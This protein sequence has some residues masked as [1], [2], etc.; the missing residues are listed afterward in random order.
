[1]HFSKENNLPI[2]TPYGS[3]LQYHA[4]CE[5]L[6]EL[7]RRMTNLEWPRAKTEGWKAARDRRGVVFF[8]LPDD[9]RIRGYGNAMHSLAAENV[10][11]SFWDV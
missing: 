4:T 1:M 6:T 8:Q 5:A 10:P 11:R 9:K 7:H 2:S 3:G